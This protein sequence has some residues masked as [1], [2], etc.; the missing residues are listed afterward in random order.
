MNILMYVIVCICNANGI[1]YYIE[2]LFIIDSR[3]GT[4]YIII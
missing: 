4:D 1:P 3:M 2:I